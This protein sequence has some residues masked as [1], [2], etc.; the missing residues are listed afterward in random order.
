METFPRLQK[1]RDVI[2]QY[3]NW[4]SIDRLLHQDSGFS[5]NR[6]KLIRKINKFV[7][8]DLAGLKRRNGESYISYVHGVCAIG[9][10]HSG[11][12]DSDADLVVATLMYGLVKKFP[13]Q[14][15]DFLL[16]PYCGE[17]AA[18]LVSICR[19]NPYWR[20]SE[21]K[22]A[23]IY[24]VLER[25]RESEDASRIVLWYRLHD[26]LTLP[27]CAKGKDWQLMINRET[28]E[29]YLPLAKHHDIL[30]EE[31]NESIRETDARLVELLNP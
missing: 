9:V 28:T 23:Y 31:F 29:Y 21:K 17:K 27:D 4:D 30:V 22:D 18:G 26:Q 20:Y 12:Y 13:K 1:V 7:T 8:A 14:W 16:N 10:F 6:M 24:P 11:I 15:P 19:L 3:G 25:I 2:R 5:D